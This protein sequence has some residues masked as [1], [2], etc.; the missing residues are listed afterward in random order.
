MELTWIR[1]FVTLAH[2]QHFTKTSEF[3]NMSQPTVSIH[4]KK[5]EQSLGVNLIDRSSTHLPFTLTPAGQKVFADGQ[6]MIELWK[7]MEHAGEEREEVLLRIGSTNTVSEALLP[8]FVKKLKILYPHVRLQMKIHNHNRIVELL[9]NHELD[10]AI[11][12]G[13]K[14]IEP[15]QAEVICRDELRFFANKGMNLHSSPLILREKGSGTRDYADQFIKTEQIHPAEII[16]AGSHHL[17]KQL[18]LRG[19]GIAFLSSSMVKEEVAAGKLFP[20]DPYVIHR[21]FYSVCPAD[22]AAGGVIRELIGVLKKN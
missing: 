6:K 10:L 8:D 19:L 15:F 9:E 12:E 16:E 18:A 20:I 4:V 5:L 22:T 21:P 13:T 11:V 14:G 17:I 3:L 1:T 7:S 2:F